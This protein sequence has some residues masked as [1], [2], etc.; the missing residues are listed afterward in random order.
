MIARLDSN[1]CGLRGQRRAEKKILERDENWY[2]TA[3][4]GS[5]VPNF[6]CMDTQKHKRTEIAC[7][8]ASPRCSSCFKKKFLAWHRARLTPLVELELDAHGET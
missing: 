4:S 6:G 8:K 2:A 5:L 7:D 3:S 1:F